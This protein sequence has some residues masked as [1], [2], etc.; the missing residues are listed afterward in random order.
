TIDPRQDVPPFRRSL[1]F[2]HSRDDQHELLSMFDDADIL[3]CYRRQETVLPQQA[4]ALTNSK[5]VLER[6]AD[7]AANI[8][9]DASAAASSESDND[10]HD[11][12]FAAHAFRVLLCREPTAVELDASCQALD[13]WRA[14]LTDEADAARAS[15][16][17]LIHA[18][19]N[20]ND[21]VTI[22]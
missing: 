21:F 12:A 22:R 10:V 19:L 17:R 14:I 7:I 9:S 16:E 4:L 13:K 8:E 15:R 5:L 20:H 11:R 6:A 3:R 1:Y 18:L 2:T